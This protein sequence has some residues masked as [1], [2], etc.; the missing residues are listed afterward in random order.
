MTTRDLDSAM[1]QRGEAFA[2]LTVIA[3]WPRPE[4]DANTGQKG[5][6]CE[7]S[8]HQKAPWKFYAD[9]VRVK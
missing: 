1:F 9:S 5:D 6:L 2:L 8:R 3:R 4:L 7:F